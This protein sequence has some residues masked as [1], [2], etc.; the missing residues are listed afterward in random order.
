MTG[1]LQCEEILSHPSN[2]SLLKVFFL[3]R[4][5][6]FDYL[7]L[8]VCV[9]GEGRCVMAEVSGHLCGTGSLLPPFHRLWGSNSDGQ[10]CIPG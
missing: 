9:H 6:L 7:F 8:L 5:Y 10:I 2:S 3:W 4:L 1:E